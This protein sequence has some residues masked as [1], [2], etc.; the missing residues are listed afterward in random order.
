MR[1]DLGFVHCDNTPMAAV[2]LLRYN[3]LTYCFAGV[4]GYRRFTESGSLSM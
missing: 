4:S 2:Q 3:C 1:R